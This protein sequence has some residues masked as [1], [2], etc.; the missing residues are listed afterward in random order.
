MKLL[1]FFLVLFLLA[2]LSCIATDSDTITA[3]KA[4]DYIGEMKTVHGLVV[5]TRYAAG[6]AWQSLRVLSKKPGKAGVQ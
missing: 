2:F 4:K 3:D 1:N 5:S 6:R